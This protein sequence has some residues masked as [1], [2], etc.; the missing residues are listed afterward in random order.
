MREDFSK[1]DVPV[2]VMGGWHDGYNDA[3]IRLAKNLPNCRLVMGPWSHEWPDVAVPGPNVSSN[4]N[5]NLSCIHDDKLISTCADW[6]H[7]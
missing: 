5:N 1:V 7:A 3:A 6:L 4:N 2:L